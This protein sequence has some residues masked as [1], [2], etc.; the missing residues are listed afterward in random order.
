ME[1]TRFG[2]WTSYGSLGQ[3]NGGEAAKVAERLG[4]GVLWLG[5]S[6]ELP[7]IRPM[8]EATD[9][10]IVATSIVN[11]WKYEPERLCEEFHALEADFPGRVLV[12]VGISH[13]EANREYQKPLASM[14]SFLDG[15]AAAPQPIPRE[16]LIVAALGPKML[17]LSGERTLGTIPYFVDAQHTAF[18]RARLAPPTLV[19]P[20]LA[21]VVDEDADRAR[22][23]ARTYAKLYLGL[24]N[25]TANL[26][27]FDYDE[28]DLADGGSERLIDTI[29]PQG[30]AAEL[31]PHIQSHLDAGAD[32]VCLQTVGV[33]GVPEAE[34]TAMAGVLG[35]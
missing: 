26:L 19:A 30:S 7:T 29:V 33:S 22:S 2:V 25:Y 8:L 31:L 28:G 4:Y 11:V 35:L 15:I 14:V 1:L 24:R 27:R 16:R 12:G 13:P 3:E 21:I 17:D 5:G 10:I 6:P 32:H 23:T 34:W 9:R 20:E 18:A